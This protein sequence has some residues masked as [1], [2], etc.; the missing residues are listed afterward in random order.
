MI[1]VT[2]YGMHAGLD[3]EECLPENI[4]DDIKVI[5]SVMSR[6]LFQ[7]VPWYKLGFRDADDRKFDETVAEL[8]KSVKTII[9]EY[10]PN[11]YKE[12]SDKMSTMLESLWYSL[13]HQDINKIETSGLLS[14]SKAASKMSIKNMVGNLLTVISAG[15]GKFDESNVLDG[16]HTFLITLNS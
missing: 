10:D 7:L 3:K 9:E 1:R 6:R 12:K 4:V 13:N 2:H 16:D 11:A 14:A 5:F 8:N 15:Y